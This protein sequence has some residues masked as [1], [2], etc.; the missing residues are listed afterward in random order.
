MIPTIQPIMPS[1]A[2]SQGLGLRYWEVRADSV[3]RVRPSAH[4]CARV[5]AVFYPECALV[6]R[7]AQI[8]TD[9]RCL[10]DT[11]DVLVLVQ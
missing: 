3:D 5:L 11:A 2:F 8:A 9:V 10:P 6:R 4:P 1:S 7:R